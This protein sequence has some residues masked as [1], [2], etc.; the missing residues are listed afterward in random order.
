MVHWWILGAGF[1]IDT[2][3]HGGCW[4]WTFEEHRRF[5]PGL[6]R[7]FHDIWLLGII[8]LALLIFTHFLEFL[9]ICPK[10]FPFSA[11][12]INICLLTQK[13]P[14]TVGGIWMK[15]CSVAKLATGKPIWTPERVS[16][17]LCGRF[18]QFR[19]PIS[20]LHDAQ[21]AAQTTCLWLRSELP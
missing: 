11:K 4:Q 6:F 1:P 21:N 13:K 18:Y 10:M 20:W 19:S 16:P 7:V 3:D 15:Y 12:M 8:C 17:V 5:E 14:H 9:K 2:G